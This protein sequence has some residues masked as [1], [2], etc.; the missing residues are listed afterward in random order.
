MKELAFEKT[1]CFVGA[2]KRDFGDSGILPIEAAWFKTTFDAKKGKKTVISISATSR[3]K[4]Y[5]NGV[6]VANGPC[7]GQATEYYCDNLDLTPYIIDGKNQLMAKVVCF[8]PPEAVLADRR[9]FG[10]F[11]IIGSAAGP[12]LF[13]DGSCGDT[14]L[15][16][17]AGNWLVINDDSVKWTD[18]YEL[19]TCLVGNMEVAYSAGLK[20]I[21]ARDFEKAVF[22]F[23]VNIDNKFGELPPYPLYKRPIPMLYLAPSKG[24][25]AVHTGAN[26]I[27]YDAGELTTGYISLNVKAAKGAKI[28]ITYA[29]S[30]SGVE[31]DPLLK[32]RRDDNE[33]FGFVGCSDIF[34]PDSN[35]DNYEPFW[36]RTF[37]FIRIEFENYTATPAFEPT[38][39]ETGFPLNPTTTIEADGWVPGVWDI[40]LRT[41]QRCMHE[42]YED[43]PYYEQLQYI[44]DTRLQMLFTYA[45]GGDISLARKTLHDYHLSSMPSGI[46]QARYPSSIRQVIVPFPP[47]W[48]SML[49]DY[50]KHTGDKSPLLQY[51]TTVE[52]LLE[53]YLERL[54]KDGLLEKVGYWEF[55]DWAPEW[56][57]NE[58][59]PFAAYKGPSTSQNLVLANALRQGAEVLDICGFS[60]MGNH[61]KGFSDNI[62]N[63]ISKLCYNADK[64]L[65][66]EGPGF[67][68]YTQHSQ[69]WAVLM[70]LVTGAEAKALMERTLSD[71]SLVQCTFPLQFYLF[72]ALETAGMYE[73]TEELWAKWWQP[74]LE[75]DVTTVPETPYNNTRSDCHAWG[76][77]MLYEYPAKILGVH[78]L[79]NGYKKI[80]I[81]PMGMFLG[82][83]KG[84]VKTPAGAVD[85]SW[86]MDNGTFKASVS[87]P[88]GVECVLFT[89][90]GKEMAFVGSIEV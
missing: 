33:N 14:N 10:P 39:V 59:K 61:Y 82:K 20:E 31:G 13:V 17:S 36:F 64:K 62:I 86:T 22:R 68:E 4:L 35:D 88:A 42:T 15:S 66:S 90:D 73:R 69:M 78:A 16:T 32:G 79:E 54:N 76:A 63:S 60:E 84:S 80:G 55:L 25:K 52:H 1:A 87:A 9:N 8:P 65:F 53:W 48:I 23:K 89:P 29:E 26:Y 83:A 30:Y 45:V 3:Y 56:T 34:Y 18:T 46:L 19:A 24:V 75:L 67:D 72:R 77:L 37:R 85:V 6:M 81:R 7:K 40:S 27:D 71:E 51:R 38:Y 43:C 21:L 11:S 57:E 47:H 41:L 28:T 70:G 5:C 12:C 44:L 2:P 74:L 50:Y 49:L 58:G